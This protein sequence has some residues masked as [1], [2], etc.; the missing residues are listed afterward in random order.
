[1]AGNIGYTTPSVM[2]L[3]ATTFDSF[4]GQTL[5]SGWNPSLTFQ[6]E[7][8]DMDDGWYVAC[9]GTSNCKMSY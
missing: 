4:N 8:F 2:E 9:P 6:L 5:P 3:F 7:V 1:M